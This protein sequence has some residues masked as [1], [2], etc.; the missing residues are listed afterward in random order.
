MKKLIQISKYAGSRYVHIPIS[1]QWTSIYD[2]AP[3]VGVGDLSFGEYW[4]AESAYVQDLIEISM[5][6]EVPNYIISGLEISK[7]SKKLLPSWIKEGGVVT[8]DNME[9]LIRYCMRGALWCRLHYSDLIF[10]MFGY[11]LYVRVGIQSC[12]DIYL[13]PSSE[14]IGHVDMSADLGDDDY[15]Y[16]GEWK[17]RS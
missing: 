16:F 11:D 6:F 8:V 12:E 15:Y 7:S 13:T 2:C 1:E 4:K 9:F 14:F 5:K 10:I 17:P 3:P